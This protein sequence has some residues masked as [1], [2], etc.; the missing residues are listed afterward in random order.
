[1]VSK[2]GGAFNFYVRNA[3]LRDSF[4]E[5]NART[6]IPEGQNLW[7]PEVLATGIYVRHEQMMEGNEM[8]KILLNK[9]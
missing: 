9:Q 1:V 2:T 4:E 7:Q 8:D 5:I 6:D 3:P